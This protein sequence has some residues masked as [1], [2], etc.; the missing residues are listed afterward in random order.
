MRTRCY[1]KYLKIKNTL[2]KPRTTEEISKFLN[3]FCSSVASPIWQEGQSERT[4]PIFAFSSWIFLFFPNFFPDFWQIFHCQWW[5]SAPLATPVATPLT[6]WMTIIVILNFEWRKV[7]YAQSNIE[8]CLKML[9]NVI[10][11]CSHSK[12]TPSKV[13]SYDRKK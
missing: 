12:S 3:T 6:F 7:Y 4:F 8:I 11:W 1:K 10:Q 5:H 13:H 2:W 9:C